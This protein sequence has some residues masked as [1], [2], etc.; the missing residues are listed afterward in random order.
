MLMKLQTKSAH[1][2]KEQKRLD[3]LLKPAL[4]GATV[5]T[6]GGL[7]RQK[8]LNSTLQIDKLGIKQRKVKTIEDSSNEFVESNLKKQDNLNNSECTN[9]SNSL[10]LVC[11]YDSS[12]SESEL[13][14]DSPLV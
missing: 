6:F 12:N 10:A 3:I 2:C 11:E 1:E 9:S 13:N 7:K 14:K 5:T 8:A 4:P